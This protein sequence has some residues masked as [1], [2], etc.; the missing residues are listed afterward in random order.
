MLANFSGS[1]V[2]VELPGAAEW[3]DAEVLMTNV[4]ERSRRITELAP[5]EATVYRRC[6]AG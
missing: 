1:P 6:D 5:W 2:A 3:T 4:S